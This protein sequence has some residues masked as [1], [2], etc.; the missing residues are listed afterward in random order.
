MKEYKVRILHTAEEDLFGLIEFVGRYSVNA[1]VALANAIRD[2]IDSLETMPKKYPVYERQPIFR[3]MVINDV[4][5]FYIIHEELAR[6][7][8]YRIIHG[9]RD[10]I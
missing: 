2:G 9:S 4:L 10:L 5:V 8:V 1:A 7:D 3:K 6:V